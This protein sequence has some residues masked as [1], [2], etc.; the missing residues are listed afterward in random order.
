MEPK[1]AVESVTLRLR[2]LEVQVLESHPGK[3]L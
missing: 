3:W 2:I 1:E